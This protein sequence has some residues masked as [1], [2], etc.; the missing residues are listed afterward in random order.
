MI[1]HGMKVRRQLRSARVSALSHEERRQ[2]LREAE[3]R[4]ARGHGNVHGEPATETAAPARS[5]G[6]GGAPINPEAEVERPGIDWV[7]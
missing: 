5:S 4:V 7:D 6:T 1:T 2:E 3:E